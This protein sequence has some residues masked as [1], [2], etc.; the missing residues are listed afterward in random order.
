MTTSDPHYPAPR[1]RTLSPTASSACSS[2][3]GPSPYTI[4]VDLTRRPAPTVHRDERGELDIARVTLDWLGWER[5]AWGGADPG[6]RHYPEVRRSA[7]AMFTA[8]AGRHRVE[9][10]DRAGRH[11]PPFERQHHTLAK[12]VEAFESV[13][14]F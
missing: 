10:D 14:A 12:A 7:G 1:P 9:L 8:G 6:G 2:A 4:D 13:G 11:V 3:T 5:L